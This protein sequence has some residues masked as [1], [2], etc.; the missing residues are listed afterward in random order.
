MGVRAGYGGE[1]TYPVRL[2]AGHLALDQVI[3]GSNP[4]PDAREKGLVVPTP[5]PATLRLAR[6]AEVK[7]QAPRGANC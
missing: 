1:P 5:I 3:E 4:R 7:T 2:T 6:L